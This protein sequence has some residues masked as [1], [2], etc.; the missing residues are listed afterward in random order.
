[1]L[2]NAA[3]SNLVFDNNEILARNNGAAATLVLQ[4]D[5]GSVRIGNVAAPADY[6]F[7][8]NGKMICEEL[9]VK[10][11]SSGWPDYVFANDYKLK[12][13]SDLRRFIDQN[14]HLPGI[15]AAAEV[16]KNGIEVGDMQRKLME[17]VE[18]LTLY[19]LQLEDKIN[20]LDASIKN[21]K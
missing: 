2:G 7:A 17:K 3:T 1:M 4:N 20:R 5:G 10:L 11:A 8:I 15:P 18:E 21:N 19:I 16:E 6:K 13:L 12:S 9:K 14:K